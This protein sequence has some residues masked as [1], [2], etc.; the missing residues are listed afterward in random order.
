MEKEDLKKIK[1]VVADVDGTLVDSRSQISQK[2]IDAV[3]ELK[4]TGVKFALGTGRSNNMIEALVKLMGGDLCSLSNNGSLVYDHGEKKVIYIKALTKDQS[5]A[6]LNEI[7]NNGWDF[8][9]YSRT[10][11]YYSHYDAFIERKLQQ[12]TQGAF[13]LSD[14]PDFRFKEITSFDQIDDPDELLKIAVRNDQRADMEKIAEIARSVGAELKNSGEKFEAIFPQGISKQSGMQ[15]LQEY[16]GVSKEETAAIGDFDNDLPLF[17]QAKYKV[18]M[19]NASDVLKKQANIFTDSND[20]DGVAKFLL[21][22]VE[23]HQ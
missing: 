9:S 20:E 11:M 17:A 15:K 4:K 6:I 18:A 16:L 14:F 8:I 13:E 1:L 19:G 23:A 21:K 10:H 5:E 2:T 12:V 3:K 7:L 22:I